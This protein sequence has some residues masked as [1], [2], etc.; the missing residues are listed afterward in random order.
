M[1]TGKESR[2]FACVFSAAGIKLYFSIQM[3]G[4]LVKMKRVE[5]RATNTV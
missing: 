3:W 2:E 1:K 5:N 4:S